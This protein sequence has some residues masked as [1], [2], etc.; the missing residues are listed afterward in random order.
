MGAWKYGGVSYTKSAF[1]AEWIF[2]S[3]KEL[4][5]SWRKVERFIMAMGSKV[6]K[7]RMK[8]YGSAGSPP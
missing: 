7:I 4:R 6:I 5:G 1:F 8:A 3:R 2:C